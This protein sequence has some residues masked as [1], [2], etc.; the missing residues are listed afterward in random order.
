[1]VRYARVEYAAAVR[2]LPG[3]FSLG[4][5]LLS[6]STGPGTHPSPTPPVAPAGGNPF[7][8]ETDG[9]A[10][11]V[12]KPERQKLRPVEEDSGR[13]RAASS[14]GSAFRADVKEARRE[15]LVAGVRGRRRR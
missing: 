11:E 2:R 4:S 8:P 6:G 3:K 9:A 10:A 15:V 12:S 13:A 1:M 7:P 5:H 14:S